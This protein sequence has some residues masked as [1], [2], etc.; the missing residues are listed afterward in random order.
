MKFEQLTCNFSR[1]IF[2]NNVIVEIILSI[3]FRLNHVKIIIVCFFLSID[4]VCL[5]AYIPCIDT[6]LFSETLII[7]MFLLKMIF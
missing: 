6:Q 4:I 3:R 2:L 5:F 7:N 1:K